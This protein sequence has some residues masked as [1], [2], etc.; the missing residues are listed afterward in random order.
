MNPLFYKA[1]DW[2][3]NYHDKT[4]NGTIYLKTV[5]RDLDVF[6]GAVESTEY[7]TQVNI[8]MKGLLFYNSPEKGRF[9]CIQYALNRRIIG[10]R[11]TDLRP[12]S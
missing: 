12:N 3:V 2:T 4:G 8:I 11:T 1:N 7:Y 9:N 5:K 6:A 10:G